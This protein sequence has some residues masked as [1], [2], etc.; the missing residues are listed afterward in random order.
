MMAALGNGK[1]LR[2]AC[3]YSLIAAFTMAMAGSAQEDVVARFNRAVELQK[4]EAWKEA[5]EEY[6]AILAASPDYAEAHANLGA[7][8]MRQD[9]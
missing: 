7:T 1:R 8:L 3:L 9:R 4:K 2:L 6:R 5:E